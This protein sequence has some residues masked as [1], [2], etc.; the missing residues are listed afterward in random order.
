MELITTLGHLSEAMRD[1]G[2]SIANQ[3]IMALNDLAASLD[4]QNK[5]QWCCGCGRTAGE[6][7]VIGFLCPFCHV[8]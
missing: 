8:R 6:Y 5:V 3:T 7:I 4:R 2:E 1:R